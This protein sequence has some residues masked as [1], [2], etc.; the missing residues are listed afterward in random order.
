MRA[1]LLLTT[2]L[3]WPCLAQDVASGVLDG[4]Q[5]DVELTSTEEAEPDALYRLIVTDSRTHQVI[6]S[7]LA[8]PYHVWHSGWRTWVER[9]SIF[10]SLSGGATCCAQYTHTFQFK[11]IDSA[12]KLVGVE[13]KEGGYALKNNA[14]R[15][16]YYSYDQLISINLLSNRVRY[17]RTQAPSTEENPLAPAGKRRSVEKTLTISTP[18]EIRLSDFD[19]WT[20]IAIQHKH[21]DLKHIYD[22]QLIFK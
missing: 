8:W 9:N 19:Y 15:M 11:R 4:Q 20:F 17:W 22:D 5:V 2:L 1:L 18:P 6:A 16:Q 14:D 21:P 7:S 10:L 13:E 12:F 3:A